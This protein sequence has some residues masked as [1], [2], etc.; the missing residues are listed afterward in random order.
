M[1]LQTK[2]CL[3][4][5]IPEADMMMAKLKLNLDSQG[6][7]YTVQE[8]VEFLKYKDVKTGILE[9]VIR[10]MIENNIYN[11]PIEVARGK[12]PVNGKNGYYIFHFEEPEKVSGPQV[13]EDGAVEY[14][15][16]Q[17]YTI[18]EEGELLAE[19][20]PPTNGEYGYTLDNKMLAPKKGKGLPTLKGK[21]FRIEDN[22]YYALAHGRV[23]KTLSGLLIT[24]VLEILTD[25][26]I[27]S[28][29]VEF[30]GDVHIRGDVKSGMTVKATGDIEIK[31]H[32]G[33]CFIEAGGN[34]IIQNGMQGKFEGKLKAG[35]DI[36]CRFFENSQA[37]AGGNITVRSVLH[38]DLMAQGKVTIDGREAVVLGGSVHAVKGMEIHEA[39]NDVEVPTMLAAGALPETIRRSIELVSLIKKVQDEVDLLDRSAKIM[40]RMTQ[41]NVAKETANRRMKIIQAKVIKTTELK[42]YQEEQIQT[43]A[44][45]N[46]GKSATIVIQDTIYPGCSVEIAGIRYNVKSS[47]KHVK[48]VAKRDR[49]E[50]SLL[51]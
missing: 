9:D 8:L 15:H 51:Y 34:I 31:G 7:Q 35:G 40:E 19:Y 45:I 12:E 16:T 4:E 25:V 3:P 13:L 2:A 41:T 46:S 23:E 48:F 18:V 21:G 26:D 50:M 14:V 32:V 43:D 47:Y 28:G 38:S 11:V 27:S 1:E 30:D 24:N 42:R 17:E 39:G 33:N 5:V 44:L 6:Q 36:V 29:H 49:L 22:K 10:D 20:I 37:E